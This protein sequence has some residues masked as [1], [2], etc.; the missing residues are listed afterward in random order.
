MRHL[1]FLAKLFLG[2]SSKL[3]R[4]SRGNSCCKKD[5][6]KGEV[7]VVE[8]KQITLS[9]IKNVTMAS[10]HCLVSKIWR[11]IVFYVL[12]RRE[13]TFSLCCLF[14]EKKLA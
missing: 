3:L 2:V 7:N 9:K 6:G 1:R 10:S 11:K 14:S 5:Y 12:I 8:I 13:K 4:D